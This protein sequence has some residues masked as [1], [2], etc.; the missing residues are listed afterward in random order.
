MVPEDTG[1]GNVGD[2]A[3]MA[4]APVALLATTDEDATYSIEY[5]AA[6]SDMNCSLVFHDVDGIGPNFFSVTLTAG[7][8][9]S[10]INF[11]DKKCRMILGNA[12]HDTYGGNRNR[13]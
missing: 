7:D 13:I 3:P 4:S 5:A 1:N 12:T 8:I 2:A 10:G 6:M 9:S 11:V